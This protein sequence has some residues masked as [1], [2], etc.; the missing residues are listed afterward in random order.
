MPWLNASSLTRF[1]E[2]SRFWEANSSS[3]IQEFP[4]ILWNPEFHYRFHN[5]L[6][7][8]PFLTQISLRPLHSSRRPI[9]ILSA[10]LRL[11]IPSDSFSRVFHQNPTRVSS[12]PLT[13]NMPCPS[14]SSLFSAYDTRTKFGIKNA[15][16]ACALFAS[17]VFQVL[18]GPVYVTAA[19]C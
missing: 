10:H 2:Q 8:F 6:T 11:V 5:S 16:N 18:L 7:I 19:C 15:K 3:A 1:V 14:W 4:W 17:F 13:C 9:L 12:I